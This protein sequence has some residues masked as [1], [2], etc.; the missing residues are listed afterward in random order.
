MRVETI[1]CDLCGKEGAKSRQFYVD[2]KMDGAGSMEDHFESL[3]LCDDH[4][5]EAFQIA[6]KHEHD[7]GCASYVILASMKRRN[8]ESRNKRKR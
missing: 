3:D 4:S 2:R 5:W 1:C 7:V 6:Q 8:D